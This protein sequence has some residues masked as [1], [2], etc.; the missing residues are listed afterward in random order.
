MVERMLFVEGTA[1]T[2][3]GDLRQGFRCLLDQK[4]K[5][6]MIRITMG[7]D[8]RATID[9]F[10][11]S[12][13]KTN[14]LLVDLD[15][16]ESYR[17]KDIKEYNLESKRNYAFYMIQEMEAWFLS[18]PV[19]LDEFYGKGISKNIRVKDPKKIEKPDEVLQKLTESSRKGK[20]H[21]VK[22]GVELLKKLDAD[23]LC[24]KF[25]DFKR[26]IEELSK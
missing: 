6:S 10:M 13:A 9:K 25:D 15:N 1:G 24:D 26:L 12:R 20:Y 8:K 21:K 23:E 7:N 4:I 11:N 3:A 18:Q 19:I 2:D 16:E 14:F 22:H 17:S 5:G